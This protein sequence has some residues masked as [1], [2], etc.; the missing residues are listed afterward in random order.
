MPSV[1]RE[2]NRASG[3]RDTPVVEPLPGDWSRAIH[4]YGVL[5]GFLMTLTAFPMRHW[6][7]PVPMIVVVLFIPYYIVAGFL[8]ARRAG[9]AAA[10]TT[11]AVTALTGHTVVYV[12]TVLYTLINDTWPTALTWL[13]I[14]VSLTLATLFLGALAGMAGGTIAK[15]I[16]SIHD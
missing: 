8:A 2:G 13:G 11:G 16:K 5:C 10:V 4:P 9:I 6:D 3:G 7:A 1:E 15:G 12:A 14:G